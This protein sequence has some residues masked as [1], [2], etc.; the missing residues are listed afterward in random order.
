MK[1]HDVRRKR[2]SY[3]RGMYC[4][5]RIWIEKEGETYLGYGRMEL[6]ARIG[7]FGSIVQAAKSMQMSYKAAWDLVND[8][9][10][11]AP[12]PLVIARKGGRGG[13]GA[14]LSPTGEAAILEF[15]ALQQRLEDFLAVETEKL[16]DTVT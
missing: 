8:M 13:G 16:R 12:A 2:E 7:E 11:R 14:V 6:L 9:N 1:K 3:P 15:R 4:R 5:G 10:R